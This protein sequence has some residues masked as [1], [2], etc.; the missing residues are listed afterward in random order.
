MQAPEIFD[1]R[2][3]GLADVKGTDKIIPAMGRGRG[4][5]VM[6]AR[7]LAE[8]ISFTTCFSKRCTV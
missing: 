2:I 4:K 5:L 1:K 7:T 3:F 8:G 6:S